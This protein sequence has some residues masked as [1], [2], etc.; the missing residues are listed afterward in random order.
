MEQDEASIDEERPRG[1]RRHAIRRRLG[2][3]LI[4]VALI[5]AGLGGG[6]LWSERRAA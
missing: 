3:A 6:V 4:G 2:Q 5:V 1:G